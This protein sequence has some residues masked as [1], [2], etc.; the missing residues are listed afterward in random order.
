MKSGSNEDEESP[1]KSYPRP[2][3]EHAK[4]LRLYW[5]EQPQLS[6]S[7]HEAGGSLSLSWLNEERQAQKNTL[8]ATVK[9]LSEKDRVNNPPFGATFAVGFLTNAVVW[10][11]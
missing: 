11:L 1:F 6:K 7:S 5:S 3:N 4:W 10:R 2:N 8:V 9:K